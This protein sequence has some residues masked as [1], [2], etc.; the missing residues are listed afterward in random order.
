MSPLF[1]T[2][3]SDLDLNG[4]TLSF[5]TQ[6]VDTTY[7]AASGIATFIGIATATFPETQTQRATKTGTGYTTET[8]SKTFTMTVQGVGFGTLTFNAVSSEL[9]I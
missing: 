6:P 1:P 9:V 7:S 4:P 3:Q 8:Y 2:I 5:T